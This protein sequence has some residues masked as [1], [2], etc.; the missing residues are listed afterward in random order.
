MGRQSYQEVLSSA[1]GKILPPDH[2]MTI[3]VERVM[4]K[5]IPHAPIEGADW[6]V[7]VIRDDGMMNAFVLPGYASLLCA[8]SPVLALDCVDR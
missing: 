3:M 7:H 2:P 5:L 6:R 1:R 4:R 8:A